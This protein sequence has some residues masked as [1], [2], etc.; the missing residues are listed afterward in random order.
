LSELAESFEIEIVV[1]DTGIGVSEQAKT[2]LFDA[3]T[4]AESSTSRKFGGTGLGLTITKQLVELMNGDIQM[5]SEQGRGSEFS[6][7]NC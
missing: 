6:C 3:F 4:Q 2:Q 1:T 5:K 7:G